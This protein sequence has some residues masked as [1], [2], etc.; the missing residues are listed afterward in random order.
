MKSLSLF[1]L[2]LSLAAP[3][4]AQQSREGFGFDTNK[5]VVTGHS[6]GGHLAL[7]T[8]M[9]PKE[10]G[11]DVECSQGPQSREIS[12]ASGVNFYGITDVNDLLYPWRRRRHGPLY[13][14]D[15]MAKGTDRS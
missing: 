12:V 8:G 11:L 9:P 13:P 1:V 2:L 10:A 5:I 6:A 14:R 15:Q 3:S 4:F 7:T